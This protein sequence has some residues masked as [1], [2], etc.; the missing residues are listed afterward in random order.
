MAVW[1]AL[2]GSQRLYLSCPAFELLFDGTR[3]NGKSE[4]GLVEFGAEIGK[5]GPAWQGTIVAPSYK[6]LE[7][8]VGRSQRIYR[9][10]FPQA[11]F[12]A[13]KS[14]YRWRWPDGESLEFR[15]GSTE[16]DYF[17]DFHGREIPFVLFEE[18][19]SWKDDSFYV[20]MRSIVR[21]GSH[22]DMPRKLRANTNP[23]GVGR[24]WVKA[25]FIDPCKGK[26]FAVWEGPDGRL[27]GRVKGYYWENPYLT[28]NDPDY[29]SGISSDRNEARRKAWLLGD[30]DAV[31]DGMFADVWLASNLLPVVPARD[32]V[33]AGWTITRAFDWGSTRPF[34]VGWYAES[35]GEPLISPRFPENRFDPIK[36]SVVRF[37]EWYGWNGTPDEGVKMLSTN[38]AKGILEREKAMGIEGQ[39][40]P[41]AAD[42]AIYEVRDGDSVGAKMAR[43]GVDFVPS[44]K[45]P[46]SRVNGWEV[47]RDM[48]EA[49]H[50]VDKDQNPIPPEFPG[51]Y[52]TSSCEQFIRTVLSIPRDKKNQDD[53]D[54]DTED[55]IADEFR[56]EI[57]KKPRPTMHRAKM[58]GH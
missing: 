49:V 39:V 50:P 11:R 16:E 13:S 48:M 2:P 52:C 43:A 10:W 26:D 22:R 8:T 41:G 25:R 33:N 1:S 31:A 53:V 46:G 40:Q 55:H 58:K 45:G 23:Y 17:N 47:C 15:A 29:I 6:R 18:L 56:Y 54:T 37:A 9:Q 21:S 44:A 4:C 51:F 5:W 24:P 7:E 36:G 27:V 14:E 20:A 3:G 12:L 32:F 19:C 28:E 57:N 38:I 34:S 42:S 30:W 35:N